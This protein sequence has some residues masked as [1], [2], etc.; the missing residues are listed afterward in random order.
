MTFLE[1]VC[2]KRKKLADVLLD[3][4]YSGIREIVEQLY[5]DRAHFIY[6]LLQNAEDTGATQARFVLVHECLVFEHNGRPFDENDIWRITNIGKSSKSDEQDKIGR[7]GV[8]FK[9]VFAYSETPY[10]WSPS[11]SF[12]IS[13]L[14]LPTALDPNST[15]FGD[16]THFE[17]PF[18]NPKK[19]AEAA[20]AEIEAGLNELAETTLLFLTNLESISWRIGEVVSGEVQR[21]KHSVHHVEVVRQSSSSSNSHF[22][23]FDRSV[24]G[25][26]QQQVAIA[27]ALDFLPTSAVFDPS[28]LLSAQMRIVPA[29][30]GRVAV[31]FPAEKETSGLRFHMHAPF[32][33]EL[34]RASIK[35]TPSNEPLFRQLAALTAASLHEIRDL[36]LLGI[37]CL[38]VLPNPQDDQIPARYRCIRDAVVK[39]MNDRALTPTHLKSH[40]PAKR[41]LQAKASLK[42]LLSDET[43]AFL[44]GREGEPLQWA[45]G[46]TQRNSNADRFLTGLAITEWDIDD[47]VDLVIEKTSDRLRFTG[48]SMQT[49][50]DPDF[51]GWLSQNPPEWHQRLY[52]LLY[53]ERGPIRD[54]ERLRNARIVR[55]SNGLYGLGDQCYFPSETVEHDEV[56]PRVD[57]KVFRSGKSKTQQDNARNLLEAIGVRE[58]GE[59]EQVEAIL[60]GRYTREHLKPYKQD[61]KRFVALVEK[62]STKAGLFRDFHIFET[63]DGKWGKPSGVFLDQPFLDTGLSAYYEALGERAP[64]FQL[65]HSYADRGVALKKVTK[66]AEAVGASTQIEIS[67]TNCHSNPQ[68]A[69]LRAVPGE[70]Y[71]SPINRDFVIIG[72]ETLLANPSIPLARVI[73]RTMCSVP[74]HPD[75][76]KATYRKSESWGARQSDS[77]LV[78]QLRNA[79]WIPQGDGIFVRPEIA[80]SNLLPDGFPFD[81]SQAWLKA[82]GFGREIAMKSEEQRQKEET[83]KELGFRDQATLERAK[84][85]GALPPEEQER[86]LADREHP[87]L[88]ELPEHEPANP[89]RRAERVRSGAIVAP[90]R[91]SEER[92][93]S[94][95]VGRDDVKQAANQYLFQ[96][97]MNSDGNMICQ[98]C[99]GKLPFKLN[100]GSD[101]FET[102]EFLPE[103]KKH[104]YQ[105]YLALC[106]N[107]SAMFQY[108][109]GSTGSLPSMVDDM[110]GNDL[111]IVLAQM[112]IAIYF[113]KTHIADLKAVI[114]AENDADGA[115]SV[116]SAEPRVQ[117]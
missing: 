47:F 7:F 48:S 58:V 35:E 46:I 68:Y 75:C 76:L 100:D 21:V 98:L 12:K 36:G 3:D 27:F 74:S 93:R 45:V 2:A 42:D 97:Y 110:T 95:S 102:V 92:T 99:K 53:T 18:N 61:F 87:S 80:L 57:V 71:T 26:D 15:E 50:P 112:P 28:K 13:H 105:N 23:K 108:V 73:W 81:P 24:E 16:W 101:Y 6:E 39:E 8:G 69:Y 72:L 56:M 65:A 79:K 89:E 20:Y 37:D 9:A 33:P 106:P 52:A 107:H 5:P 41:L 60:K 66:F 96:Q 29:E 116:Q 114:K 83:A 54:F 31:F 11:F 51:M 59:A 22:L 38:S 85:F 115:L 49:G 62:D 91:S 104:H 94:V 117:A 88:P 70:R 63:I 78:H 67:R 43:L 30:K 10:I 64:R 77:Q 55:L 1:E 90:A 14:V 103:L 113:T 32:V 34:S 84:R 44:V 82:I 111:E 40:A 109:N 25:L 17:F 86:I 4:D 19:S